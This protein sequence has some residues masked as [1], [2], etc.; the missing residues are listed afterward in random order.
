MALPSRSKGRSLLDWIK[1]FFSTQT[2]LEILE[3]RRE[4]REMRLLLA[5][6][7][8]SSQ[9]LSLQ[10]QASLDRVISAKFDLPVTV[11]IPYTQAKNAYNMPI[12]HFSDVM[13]VEDDREFLEKLHG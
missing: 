4:N 3:L 6:A 2:S 9:E 5:K 12:E 13:S 10:Q 8:K 11:S 7:L 1:R